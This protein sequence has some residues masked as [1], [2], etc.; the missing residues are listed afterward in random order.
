MC[1]NEIFWLKL[2]VE[3][4]SAEQATKAP[5]WLDMRGNFVNR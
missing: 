5:H 3:K 1:I 2:L 4:L